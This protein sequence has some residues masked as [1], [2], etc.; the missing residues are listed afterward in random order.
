MAELARAARRLPLEIRLLRA[1]E[2]SLYLDHLRRLG[3]EC[4][5]ERFGH[6]MG[7]CVLRAY[8]DHCLDHGDLVVGYFVDGVM[9]GAG[10]LHGLGQGPLGAV[11]EAAFSVEHEWRG[12]EVGTA[13]FDRIVE[14]AK[15]LGAREILFTCHAL[16][17]AMQALARKYA[18]ELHF[19]ADEATGRLVVR[20]RV[21][22]DALRF[23]AFLG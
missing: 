23:S 5:F 20:P 18:A 11:G 22:V 13:L 14:T 16:N 7:D 10:E 17:R 15:A 1:G 19:D 8:A 3:A 4:R 6:A 12:Q 2:R 9:R 21:P